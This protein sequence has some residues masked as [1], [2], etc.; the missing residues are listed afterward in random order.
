M[1][2]LAPVSCVCVIWC[3]A[4]Q[5]HHRIMWRLQRVINNGKEGQHVKHFRGTQRF[6]G[7]SYISKYVNTGVCDIISVCRQ[8]WVSFTDQNVLKCGHVKESRDWHT[9][10]QITRCK[11]SSMFT[12]TSKYRHAVN[13][14]LNRTE[15]QR[16]CSQAQVQTHL[17]MHLLGV[18][19]LMTFINED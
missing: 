9:R 18:T 11:N 16:S 19:L 10:N 17:F 7:T 1:W 14:Q 8:V 2:Q 3:H 5:L 13:K 15:A 6:K 4:L 12:Q